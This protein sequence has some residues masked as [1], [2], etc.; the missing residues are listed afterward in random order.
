MRVF[1]REQF[2]QL[3]WSKPM[4]AL[5]RDFGLSD[6]ALHKI[7]R[8]HDVPTPP[9]GW[10]A[11]QQAGKKVIVARLPKLKAG[12]SERI[13]ITGGELRREPDSIAA[14]REQARVIASSGI[15]SSAEVPPIVARTIAALRR[16]K[17]GSTGLVSSEGKLIRCEVA[18][19]SID[20]LEG[21]LTRV[22]AAGAQQGFRLQVRQKDV[23]FAGTEEVGFSVVETVRRTKHELT[24]KEQAE[25]ERYERKRERDIRTGSWATSWLRRPQVPEDDYSPTGQLSFELEQAYVSG[26]PRRTFRDGKVQRL[27]EMAGD[28]AVGIA[29]LA[30]AKTQARLEREAAQRAAEEQRLLLEQAA[31]AKHVEERRMAGLEQIAGEI[32]RIERLQILLERV[33]S[34]S[35][36]PRVA[37]F[38]SWIQEQLQRRRAGLTGEALEERFDHS[39][40]FG[41]DDD[42]GFRPSQWH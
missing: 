6:V 25:L 3:V 12:I 26:S 39:R 29:V 37:E 34:D 2:H 21:A 30:A 41:S 15:H 1:T 35:G 4:T 22:A 9:P 7:C 10:W 38:Q 8:K 33:S 16:A 27:G 32:H 11:K 24:P 17:P 18:S 14:A 19:S 20:R 40:L 28:I 36:G 13:V 23:C 5:A 31:R 42:Q